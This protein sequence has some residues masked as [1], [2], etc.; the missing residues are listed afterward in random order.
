MRALACRERPACALLVGTPGSRA[1]LHVV[2]P[3]HK[4]Q[5]DHSNS[6]GHGVV[7]MRPDGS[8]LC[9]MPPGGV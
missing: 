7:Y 9:T 1:P 4:L 5:F 8:V 3:N 6:A 2:I